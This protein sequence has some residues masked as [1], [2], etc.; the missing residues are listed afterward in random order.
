MGKPTQRQL[1][2]KY[3]VS[4][5]VISKMAQTGVDIYDEDAVE[6]HIMGQRSRPKSWINGCPWK[7]S[8]M[9]D[10]VEGMSDVEL[11]LRQQ[12]EGAKD[13]DTA[14]TLKMKIDALYKLRQIDIQNREYIHISEIKED[15]TRIGSATQAA[16]NKCGSDL[17]AMLEGLEI[18]TMEKIIN[19]Y[20][21][22]IDDELA[23]SGSELYTQEIKE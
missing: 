15:W 21:R 7:I 1:A 23:D 22:K 18:T 19:K 3:E 5:Y 6:S 4:Q 13:Y 11:S 2:D 8:E 14:R 20:M 12:V 16:H 9:R 10:S 17:P